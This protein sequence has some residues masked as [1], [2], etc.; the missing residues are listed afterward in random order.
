MSQ[1]RNEAITQETK[2]HIEVLKALGFYHTLELP[3][4][5]V[6]P[7]LLSVDRLRN[8]LAQYE[9]PADLR[10]KRVLDIG[11]WDGF[12]TFEME[13]RGAHVVALDLFHNDKFLLA[14]DMQNSKA[15][16]VV[17]DICK[18]SSKDLGRF[19]IVLFFGVLYHVKH[20]VMALENIC[21]MTLDT[22]YVESYVIDDPAD[23]NAVPILEF[24]ER[25]ELRGQYD[26]WCGPNVTCLMAMARAAGFAEV[27]FES[28]L[29]YRG[30]VTCRRKWSSGPGAEPAP[31]IL[32]VENS[33]T[34]DHDFS[35]NRDDYLSV[36]FRSAMP[37]LGCDDVFI[38][39]GP[40]AAS[41][42]VVADASADG[43]VAGCKLPP[44]LEPG[45][46]ELRLRVRQSQWSNALRIPVDA[47]PQDQ[48]TPTDAALD[49]SLVTDGKTWD[50]WRVKAGAESTLS[51][52][53]RGI[54]DGV[55][56]KHLLVLL[57][58]MN[59]PA[60]YVSTTDADGLKQVNATLPAGLA[61]GKYKLRLE[62]SGRISAPVDVELV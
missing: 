59:L 24:Y 40:Y 58:G 30:H 53:A 31:E 25:T 32:C 62:C 50:R 51:L 54:P 19:D 33:F 11:A 44:G 37:G 20:P 56:K 55:D 4:G 6:I 3:N 46:H 27:K 36:Y 21:S 47:P 15:E 43:W 22:A 52:W 38:D 2:Q 28:V 60:I 57:N 8:R 34:R 35:T 41:A 1:A 5:E 39:V 45:W 10:G 48:N 26:N 42:G 49:I 16:Y 17:G 29:D 12:Y 7:G 18:L 23:L 9:I 13:R 14:R 61:P